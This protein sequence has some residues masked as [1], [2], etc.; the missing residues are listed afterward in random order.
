MIMSFF[1]KPIIIWIQQLIKQ[2]AK[3]AT[4]S[5]ISGILL[6][7]TRSRSDLIIEN[8]LLRQ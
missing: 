7:L 2:W 4:Q 1:W 8:A 6:D 3:P 5:S